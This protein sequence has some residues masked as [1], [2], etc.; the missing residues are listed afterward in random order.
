MEDFIM[1]NQLSMSENRQKRDTN[2]FGKADAVNVKNKDNEKGIIDIVPVR[3]PKPGLRLPSSSNWAESF[4]RSG[5]N[6]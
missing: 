6:H 1:K 5:S 4:G 3:F 2:K